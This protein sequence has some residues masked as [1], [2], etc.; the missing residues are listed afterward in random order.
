M[1][2]IYFEIGGLQDVEQLNNRQVNHILTFFD[3]RTTGGLFG[4]LKKKC[5]RKVPI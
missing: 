3:P 1:S 2:M 4:D 5:Q